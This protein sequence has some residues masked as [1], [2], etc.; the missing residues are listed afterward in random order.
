MTVIS[1]LKLW[2]YKAYKQWIL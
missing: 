1:V 2:I